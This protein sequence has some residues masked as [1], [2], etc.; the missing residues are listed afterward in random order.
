ML[1]FNSQEGTSLD[2]TSALYLGFTHESG[3]L[4]GWDRLTLGKPAA[5]ESPPGAREVERELAA[6][7]GTE[8]ALLAPSTLHLFGDLLTVLAERDANFFVD[9]GAYPVARWGAE[10]VAAAGRLVLNFPRHD[11]RALSAAIAAAGRRMPVVVADGFSPSGGMLAPIGEYLKCTAELNGLVVID[12]T[13]A[14]G[15]LGPGPSHWAPFGRSGGGSLRHARI[16]SRRVLLA[17]SLAKAFGAPLAM[18]AGS[19]TLVT[20]FERKSATRVHCSPPSVAAIRAAERALAVNRRW[21]DAL[22]FR[23]AQRVSRFRC[24]IRRLG[25]EGPAEL[26]PVQVLR[27]PDAIDAML[28]HQALLDEGIRTVL[29]RANGDR[30]RISFVLT[31]RHSPSEI[32]HAVACLLKVISRMM[33]RR[34]GA[35]S[36]GDSTQLTGESAQ[37]ELGGVRGVRRTGSVHTAPAEI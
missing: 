29:H 10:R 33:R 34:K 2:F 1:D 17:S 19:E 18:L 37:S 25:L 6:L 27:L 14:L 12:D 7:V 30:A 31:A 24:G 32:D 3:R 11:P 23:L 13:Q 35:K 21:G 8:R 16:R 28:A 26:F 4:P 15:L 22:R 5:L 20:E 9:D 36:N